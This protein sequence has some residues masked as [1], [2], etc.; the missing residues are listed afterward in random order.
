MS[1]EQEKAGIIEKFSSDWPFGDAWDRII[2]DNSIPTIFS[3][4]G[5]HYLIDNDKK[6]PI[7]SDHFSTYYKIR[8]SV[9][10]FSGYHEK[11]NVREEYILM[12]DECHFYI[13]S[14]YCNNCGKVTSK[15]CPCG[16]LFCSRKCQKEAFKF[17]KKSLL[18]QYYQ[19]NNK[20][21]LVL[22][23]QGFPKI[24]ELLS[25]MDNIVYSHGSELS[26]IS[27][28][29]NSYVPH[30]KIFDFSSETMKLV[31][32]WCREK[33]TLLDSV[34]G[35]NKTIVISN[36]FPPWFPIT[37]ALAFISLGSIILKKK[38]NETL[39]IQTP[40]F[41]PIYIKPDKLPLTIKDH[42][43]TKSIS[44][45]PYLMPVGNCVMNSIR[46]I[47]RYP[48]SDL[49]WGRHVTKTKI[50]EEITCYISEIHCIVRNSGDFLDVTESVSNQNASA[51]TEGVF[52]IHTSLFENGD[53]FQD[54][55][56]EKEMEIQK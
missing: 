14:N 47:S 1:K 29:A 38:D 32:S 3:K 27:L 16:A 55:N 5:K 8:N 17:H 2:Q 9:Q 44:S 52:C 42:V 19:K 50:F 45:S 41:H 46:W 6:F 26:F 34:H 36:G 33:I 12:T 28:I 39:K 11:H 7:N 24:K 20:E 13:S 51:S 31:D 48:N 22:N 54:K 23:K 10:T 56:N 40:Y 15:R 21:K 30:E 53:E 35:R 43:Q 18:H 37:S 49:V 4:N 25:I